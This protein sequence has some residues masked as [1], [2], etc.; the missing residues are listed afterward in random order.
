M[1]ALALS[2]DRLLSIR[3]HAERTYPDECCGLILGT[4][5]NGIKTAVEIW[6]TEN[7][8]LTQATDYWPEQQG[9]TER[10]RYAIKPEAMLEAMKAGRDRNLSIIGIYHSHPDC[11]AIPSEFDRISAWSQYSYLIVSVQQGKVENLCNWRLDNEGNFQP[12]EILSLESTEIK[13]S[14]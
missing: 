4:I 9:L 7:A 13:N 1:S 8:W 14:R 6:P 3:T 2:L 11:P 10:G 12:E 5:V